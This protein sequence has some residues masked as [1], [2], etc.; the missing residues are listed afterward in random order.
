VNAATTIARARGRH[1]T[2]VIPG[3]AHEAHRR[4]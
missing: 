1:V 2:P 3:H 4:V